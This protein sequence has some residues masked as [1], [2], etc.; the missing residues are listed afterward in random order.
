MSSVVSSAE[1]GGGQ[2]GRSDPNEDQL[3][4]ARADGSSVQETYVW[5]SVWGQGS[6]VGILLGSGVAIC[7]GSGVGILQESG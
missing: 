3:R 6:G 5:V 1:T 2:R 7:Q 4:Q